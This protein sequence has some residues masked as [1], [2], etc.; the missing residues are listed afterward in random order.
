[1]AETEPKADSFYKSG[2]RKQLEELAK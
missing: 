2:G 1:M